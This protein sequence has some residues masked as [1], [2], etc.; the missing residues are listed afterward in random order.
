MR[1]KRGRPNRASETIKTDESKSSQVDRVL[2]L[3][4]FAVSLGSLFVAWY[5]SHEALAPR[6]VALTLTRTGLTVF[7]DHT[8]CQSRLRLVN[9][10]GAA[11]SIVGLD[12]VTSFKGER[13]QADSGDY[14][15]A[16]ANAPFPKAPE[17]RVASITLSEADLDNDSDDDES[18]TFQQPI[19]LPLRIDA[20][21]PLDLRINTD[22]TY[23]FTRNP[24]ELKVDAA[25]HSQDFSH[26]IIFSV[27]LHTATGERVS[28]PAHVC[29]GIR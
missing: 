25:D 29:W 24:Y 10:G 27:V 4:S 8:N 11:E 15:F 7:M 6:L 12:F 5:F 28:L 22:F 16:V 2:S 18:P 9:L 23:S 13:A 14:S 19:D 17:I 21:S 26:P 1:S 3:L 20:H